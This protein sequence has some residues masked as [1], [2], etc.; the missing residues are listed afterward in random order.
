M[1]KFKNSDEIDESDLE[2]KILGK[3]L[4]IKEIES[5]V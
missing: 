1:S 4:T 3:P 2:I 5:L